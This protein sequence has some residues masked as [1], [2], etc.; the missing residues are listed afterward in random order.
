MGQTPEFSWIK[1]QQ[2]PR[3]LIVQR[4][5]VF[6]GLQKVSDRVQRGT[7]ALYE[8]VWRG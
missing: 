7:A 4:K 5:S 6:V 3:E 2:Y 8:E 1:F